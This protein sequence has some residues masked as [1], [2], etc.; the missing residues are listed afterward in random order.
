MPCENWQLPSCPSLLRHYRTQGEGAGGPQ[1]QFWGRW[2]RGKASL[3]SRFQLLSPIYVITKVLNLLQTLGGDLRETVLPLHQKYSFRVPHLFTGVPQGFAGCKRTIPACFLS[4]V[5]SQ[6]VLVRNSSALS[7][8]TCVLSLSSWCCFPLKFSSEILWVS[9]VHLRNNIV[10]HVGIGAHFM[11]LS[12][13]QGGFQFPSLFC[14]YWDLIYKSSCCKKLLQ[15]FLNFCL[16]R[17]SGF[18]C[19]LLYVVAWLAVDGICHSSDQKLSCAPSSVH[20]ER[21]STGEK[22][23]PVQLFQ[24]LTAH[25]AAWADKTEMPGLQTPVATKSG[26]LVNSPDQK[27]TLNKRARTLH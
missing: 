11:E 5:F 7:F 15:C 23:N 1:C 18:V 26:D 20:E 16:P 12:S 25:L 2:P 4:S 22:H 19:I 21:H 3:H 10:P 27:T 14:W 8:Y 17:C 13:R 24:L 6:E 9:R